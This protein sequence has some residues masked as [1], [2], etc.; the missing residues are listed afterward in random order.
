LI[1]FNEEKYVTASEVAKRLQIAYGTC[2]SNILP[3]LTECHLPGRK[4]P[5]YKQSEVE[6]LSQVR[7]V[8]RQV[9]PLTLVKQE[10]DVARIEE[11]LCREAL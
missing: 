6:A 5:V 1:T 11:G 4:R 10:N 9:Q 3:L 8:E 2:K 7:T